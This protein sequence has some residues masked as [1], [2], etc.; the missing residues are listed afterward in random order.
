MKYFPQKRSTAGNGQLGFLTFFPP[1]PINGGRYDRIADEATPL[2][3]VAVRTGN[4][5]G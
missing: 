3:G 1:S 4:T 2:A 5:P